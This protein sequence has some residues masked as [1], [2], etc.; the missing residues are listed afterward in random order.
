[1]LSQALSQLAAADPNPDPAA[2][3]II[4]K[5]AYFAGLI[6]TFGGTLLYVLVLHP[7]LTRSPVAAA[8]RD[9]LRR[10]AALIL[11]AVGTWF[12]VSLYFQLAGKGARV[13]GQEIPYSEAVLPGRVLAYLT[14]P[15]KAGE[16]MST[17]AQAAIQYGLWALSAV[18]LILLWRSRLHT[19]VTQ[20]AG[21][22]YVIA[23]V[24]YAVTWVPT[25]P[26]AETFDSVL[27]S[28]LDHVHVLSVSTWVG[29]IAGLA[30][31]ATAHR[32]LSPGAG[33]VWAR[34]WSRFSVVALAA[35]GGMVV[36]GS[37]LAWKNVGGPGDLLTTEFG[38]FLLV[39][40]VL[41][42]TMVAIGALHE[43]VLMPR[44]GRAQ[45]AGEEGSVFRLAVRVFP[46]LVAVEAVLGLGVLVVLTF[47]TGSA[48]AESGSAEPVV[49]GGVIMV[50]VLLIA[51]VVTS[52]VT[53]A[54]ISA[55]LGRTAADPARVMIP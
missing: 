3:R 30:L 51:V 52:F 34:I 18:V 36:S 9:V 55:R 45:A 12:L 29:G 35:V 5:I 37:W 20:V 11:A 19:R 40:L 2:W 26:G 23:F 22:A 49:S 10:R 42:G 25:D 7:V 50:G 6:G 15:A 13:K 21:A 41:V 46:R 8:D 38:R 53:T 32:R 47:L 54:K 33:A 48:R 14:A 44:I 24:A 27:G 4:T 31:L 16:W 43:F 17:G 28:V 1:M 39:K